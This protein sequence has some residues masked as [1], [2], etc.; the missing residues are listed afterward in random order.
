MDGGEKGQPSRDDMAGRKIAIGLPD[1][2]FFML[3]TW[4]LA[5]PLSFLSIARLL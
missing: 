2:L 1:L 5:V 3:Q 4:G